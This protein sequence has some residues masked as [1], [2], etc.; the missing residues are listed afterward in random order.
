MRLSGAGQTF[1][2]LN[3][4]LDKG[5]IADGLGLIYQSLTTRAIDEADIAAEYGEI[6]DA[7]RYPADYSYVTY[8]LNPEAKWHDGEPITPRGRG[9][10][11][12]RDGQA[13]PEPALL[14]PARQEGGGD[15][16][17]TR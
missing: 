5:V 7:L 11:V 2:T 15:R 14:L 9:V 13:Q 12:R 17:P 1:D 16:R 4:I 3:P 8:R 6:A 10:V